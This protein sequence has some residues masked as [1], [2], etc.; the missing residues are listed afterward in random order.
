VFTW[1]EAKRQRNVV[2]HGGDF[3]DIERFNFATAF[4]YLDD[5]FDYGETR[6]IALG[7]IDERLHV[8]VFTRRAG[9]IHVISLRKANDR[10]IRRYTQAI[11]R[12]EGGT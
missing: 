10:E 9:D 1:D 5:R 2:K 4:T 6:E 7:F 11:G 3:A 12:V 8:L